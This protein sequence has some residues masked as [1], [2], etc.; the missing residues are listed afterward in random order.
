MGFSMGS[1]GDFL[2]ID[3]PN[4]VIEDNYWNEKNDVDQIVTGCYTRMQDDDFLKR[5]FVWGEFRSDNLTTGFDLKTTS[6]EYY[7]L[8]ENILSTNAY[9]DWAPFYSIIDR[10]NLVIDRAPKVAEADPSFTESDMQATIAEVSALR[11]MCYFYLIR[12]FKDVPYY[13][14]AITSDDQQLAYPA[15]S[16]DEI[17]NNLIADLEKVKGNALKAYPDRA[18]NYGRITQ[19][20]IYTLLA[21][22]YLWKGDYANVERYCELVLDSKTQ[23]IENNYSTT[24]NYMVNGYPIMP[25][26][27]I[28]GTVGGAYES[29]FGVGGSLESIFELDFED[30]DNGTKSNGM[31]PVFFYQYVKDIK[32]GCVSPSL[33]FA[34]EFTSPSIF[35]ERTVSSSTGIKTADARLAEAVYTN[36]N[37]DN[38][39]TMTIAKYTYFYNNAMDGLVSGGASNVSTASFGQRTSKNNA[40][41]IFYRV[42]DVM[43]MKAE[44]L[45]NMISDNSGDNLTER[46][47]SMLQVA[48]ELVKAVNDRSNT[49][50]NS[51]LVYDHYRS[52][53]T[54]NELILQ[55]RR[56]EFLFEGKRWFDLVR[57]ARREGDTKNLKQMIQMKFSGGTGASATSKL[58]NMNAIYLPYNYDELKVNPYLKQNPAYPE[59]DDSSYESTTK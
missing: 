58:T 45:A 28:S 25:D 30:E 55:E 50:K 53:L 27:T 54:M 5:L 18:A 15:T 13:T 8:T 17:L 6:A 35:L 39:S 19:N 32:A 43:L 52:K 20:A 21:D 11:A 42:S 34:T 49:E 29:V 46:E 9:T 57:M 33:A 12:T 26:V 22:M 48:F 59:G 47:D 41:W 10:C 23:Y 51:P 44:A 38:P 24:S 14:H 36:L 31:V 16:G 2:N 1:C 40:N 3:A 56:R 37:Y 7:M 4:L